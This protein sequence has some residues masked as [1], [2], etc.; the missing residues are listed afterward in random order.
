VLVHRQV[1]GLDAEPEEVLD[2]RQ[3][4]VVVA[5]E[6]P[7]ALG[8]AFLDEPERLEVADPVAIDPRGGAHLLDRHLQTGRCLR[9]LLVGLGDDRFD[10]AVDDLAVE[11]VVFE[12]PVLDHLE[13]QVLVPLHPQDRTQ[14]VHVLLVE[15]A[16]ARRCAFGLDQAFGLE[17]P[18][19][20]D[21]DVRE[22]RLDRDQDL[23]DRLIVAGGH[24]PHSPTKNTRRNRPIWTS[25]CAASLVTSTRSRFT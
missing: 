12:Q 7:G 23:A 16:V 21:R 10:L 11:R 9:E 25:S 3:H 24:A 20:A 1:P 17:E 6:V 14:T 13:G 19:L 4:D 18:D 15:L 2:D 5:V 8:A 22:L